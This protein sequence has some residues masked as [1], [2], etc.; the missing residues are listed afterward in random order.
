MTVLSSQ[1][2]I[3][4]NINKASVQARWVVLDSSMELYIDI[5]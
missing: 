3:F 5:V 1:C 4:K 2:S